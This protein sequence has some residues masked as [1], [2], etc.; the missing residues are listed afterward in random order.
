VDTQSL[1]IIASPKKGILLLQGSNGTGWGRTADQKTVAA[2]VT[3]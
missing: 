1:I 3:L 2:K